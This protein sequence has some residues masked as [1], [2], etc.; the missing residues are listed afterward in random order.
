MKNLFMSRPNPIYSRFPE[1][2][3][4]PWFFGLWALF[5][6]V[7]SL[8]PRRVQEFKQGHP[9]HAV[10]HVLAFG[11]LGS[12][13]ILTTTRRY[14]SLAIACCVAL[15]FLIE[16][17]QAHLYPDA[18]EWVDVCSDTSGV[19]VFSLLTLVVMGIFRHHLKADST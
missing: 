12:L 18:I 2:R 7:A 10:L 8:Q 15:G 13:A 3:L 14:R 4:S 5:L 1:F 11:L 16:V 9:M 6:T 17:I 19:I